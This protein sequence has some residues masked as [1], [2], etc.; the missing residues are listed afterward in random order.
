MKKQSSHTSPTKDTNKANRERCLPSPVVNDLSANVSA[1]ILTPEL[2]TSE[3]AVS[4]ESQS[5]A[6]G[7][8]VTV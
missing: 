5:S 1:G 4:C 3:P 7:G 8:E 2:L 6:Y